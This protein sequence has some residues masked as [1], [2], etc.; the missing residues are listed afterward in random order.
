[1]TYNNFSNSQPIS[2]AMPRIPT[3]SQAYL[4]NDYYNSYKPAKT[5]PTTPYQVDLYN[6]RQPN[7]SDY[8][9]D[10]LK[11]LPINTQHLSNTTNG[12]AYNSVADVLLNKE[13]WKKRWGKN[14]WLMTPLGYAPRVII[15]SLMLLK[16]TTIDPVVDTV[17]LAAS[18]KDDSLTITKGLQTGINTALMNTLINAG[19]TFDVLA[20][21]VKGFVLEGSDGFVK[22]LVGTSEEGRKQYDYSDHV[23]FGKGFGP[24]VG[25][26]FASML[27]EIFSDPL[28]YVSFGIVGTA[29]SGAK[30][31][32]TKTVDV[33]TDTAEMLTKKG[34]KAITNEVVEQT[35]DN[36]LDKTIKQ[37]TNYVLKD[38][39]AAIDVVVDT[40][41]KKGFHIPDNVAEG[42]LKN[43]VNADGVDNAAVNTIKQTAPT[44][45]YS[46]LRQN[47]A[48][49]DVPLDQLP[50][51]L[52]SQNV[53]QR[54]A[55][56]ADDGKA[57]SPGVQNYFSHTV[58]VQN[59]PSMVTLSKNLQ[60]FE[61]GFNDAAKY[62]LY[63]TS[64]LFP[65]ALGKK[66]VTKLVK[67]AVATRMASKMFKAV[68]NTDEFLDITNNSIDFDGD[69]ITLEIPKGLPETTN[70]KSDVVGKVVTD[71][72][73]TVKDDSV[74]ALNAPVTKAQLPQRSTAATSNALVPV[75]VDPKVH[76]TLNE[77]VDDLINAFRN[78]LYLTREHPSYITRKEFEDLRSK[79]MLRIEEVFAQRPMDNIL[80]FTNLKTYTEYLKMLDS[81]DAPK[82]IKQLNEKFN[83][84]NKWFT[85][86]IDETFLTNLDTSLYN[87]AIK[88]IKKAS[89]QADNIT[90]ADDLITALRHVYQVNNAEKLDN[91]SWKQLGVSSELSNIGK[92][93]IDEIDLTERVYYTAQKQS[94]V[95]AAAKVYPNKL[96]DISERGLEAA[97][98][99]DDAQ[100]DAAYADYLY[101]L[102]DVTAVQT[103]LHQLIKK[104][105][106][107]VTDDYTDLIPQVL[108][109]THRTEIYKA[110]KKYDDALQAVASEYLTFRNLLN[111]D[112]QQLAPEP[113]LK[114]NLNDL[115]HAYSLAVERLPHWD[116][117]VPYRNTVNVDDIVKYG[118]VGYGLMRSKRNLI[119]TLLENFG[120][121]E[122][123]TGF[124]K[125]LTEYAKPNSLLYR[126]LHNERYVE[127]VAVQQCI[128]SFDNIIGYINLIKQIEPYLSSVT[129]YHKQG[130]LDSVVTKLT[131]YGS[132][133]EYHI[134]KTLE[135]ILDAADL[136]AQT[137]FD[138]PKL[139]LDVT[140]WNLARKFEHSD[141]TAKAYYAGLLLESLPKAHSAEADVLNTSY[142][143]QLV[144]DLK[145]ALV[146]RSKGRN[147]LVLDIE[148]T[149]IKNAEIYQLSV[150]ML[151]PNGND[152][153]VFKTYHLPVTKV[154]E[155]TVLDKL[156]QAY[157]LAPGETPEQW[158]TRAYIKGQVDEIE[159]SGSAFSALQHFQKTFLND[160][161]DGQTAPL[162]VGHNLR[163][164]DMPTLVKGT[165]YNPKLKT[166]FKNAEVFDTYD[167]LLSQH[168]WQLDDLTRQ[169]LSSQLRRVFE[170]SDLIN[171]G[172]AKHRLID[173]G[174]LNDLNQ[175]KKIFDDEVA[176]S[177][178]T[179]FEKFGTSNGLHS[180][181][182]VTTLI[183]EASKNIS[184]VWKE[185]S[186]KTIQTSYVTSKTVADPKV[187][188]Q[189]IN[190]GVI[191]MPQAMNIMSL[192]N[193]HIIDEEKVILNPYTMY[194]YTFSNYFDPQKLIDDYVLSGAQQNHVP[195][196]TLQK[197]TRLSKKLTNVRNG[198]TAEAVQKAYKFS[199]ELLY[200]LKHQTDEDIF[201][202]PR[203]FKYLYDVNKDMSKD[204][205]VTIALYC[206]QQIKPPEDHRALNYLCKRLSFD[207]L[208]SNAEADKAL[209]KVSLQDLDELSFKK[210]LDVKR[211]DAAIAYAERGKE[212][213]TLKLRQR[214]QYETLRLKRMQR[215]AKEWEQLNAE[216][217]AAWKIRK[218]TNE[219]LKQ[220]KANIIKGEQEAVLRSKIRNASDAARKIWA[221]ELGDAEDLAR[222]V[223]QNH[224]DPI[225]TFKDLY[226]EKAL[227]SVTKQVKST[228]YG[229]THTYTKAW[230]DLIKDAPEDVQTELFKQLNQID[231]NLT[232][233]GVARIL[234]R[235]DR[236]NALKR[237]A[238]FTGGRFAFVTDSPVDLS[239]FDNDEDLITLIIPIELENTSNPVN[240]ELFIKTEGK[241]FTILK[242]SVQDA[243]P[244][245]VVF[246]NFIGVKASAYQDIITLT[247]PLTEAQLKL[248]DQAGITY[249]LI[250]TTDDSGRT[251]YKYYL[252]NAEE[253]TDDFYTKAVNI[254]NKN[255]NPELNKIVEAV[256]TQFASCVQYA[257][258]S[259]GD[260]L[261]VDLMTALDKYL[262]AGLVEQ[263]MPVHT[264]QMSGFFN[265]LRGNN[266]LIGNKQVQR[267]FNPYYAGNIINRTAYTV[268]EHIDKHI[269]SITLY[270]NFLCNN[271][272]G[273][274]TNPA[275]TALSKKDLR[276]V[277]KAHPDW[278]VVWIEPCGK[279]NK[280]K[281][282]FVVHS[283]TDFS[284]RTL[285]AAISVNAHV[286]PKD[287]M[288]E[289]MQ[290]INTF[291]LPNCVKWLQQLSLGYKLGYLSSIGTIIRNLIDSNYKNHLDNPHAF[292]IPTQVKR[293]INSYKLLSNYNDI[294]V[295]YTTASGTILS[296]VQ[297]YNALWKLCISDETTL[298]DLFARND[299][300]SRKLQQLQTHLSVDDIAYIKGRLLDPDTFDLVHGF[301][302]NGPSA[303][304][305]QKI[306]NEL[307]DSGAEKGLLNYITNKTPLKHLYS[308]NE[309]VEQ[310]ARFSRYIEELESGMSL[311]EAAMS[312][313]KT[314]FDYSDKS[315]LMMYTELIFPFMSFSFKNLNYWLDTISKN[316]LVLNEL[317]N[318][319]RSVLNYQSLFEPDYE[320]YAAYDYSF[321]FKEDVKGFGANAPWQLINAA[322][323]YHLLSGNLIIDTDKIVKHDNGYGEKDTELFAVFKLS[324]SILDAVKMLYNPLDT[325][326]QRLLPPAEILGNTFVN[327][328][329]GKA[330][331]EE[332]GVNTLLNN[333]PFIGAPLQRA[334]VGNANNVHKRIKDAGLPMA[335]TSL[336]TAAYVPTKEH[337][338]WYD[339]NYNLLNPL[340]HQTYYTSPYYTS[341][342]FTPTYSTKRNFSN[343][344]NS[345]VPTYTINKLARRTPNKRLYGRSVKYGVKNT[346]SN[347]L[348]RGAQ[349]NLIR[350]RVLDKFKYFN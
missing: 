148:T 194:N 330:P 272:N 303:G 347:L 229:A 147:I 7:A 22:G 240:P 24:G 237:E 280:T 179:L 192:L 234:N 115:K 349:D 104:Y 327:V 65:L 259:T 98:I 270:I 208:Y 160:L 121:D 132:F 66:G 341:G 12:F 9:V 313:I 342:G 211:L 142:L 48:R 307:I 131:Q 117:A 243:V 188:N 75:T 68:S 43:I 210:S 215:N 122:L 119:H 212:W 191:N 224:N 81:Y 111:K 233:L 154:P 255:Y 258:C 300:L 283:I 252:N 265:T 130:I 10:V 59:L 77:R 13:A 153:G 241:G 60:R 18:D 17:K 286:I 127:D 269:D 344:Y 177:N 116:V 247:R 248:Y 146:E 71:A 338:K 56:Q 249:K 334:G 187:Y 335:L 46:Q 203:E 323:L 317:E 78:E 296:D 242:D 227:F 90:E 245:K 124:S 164:F 106:Y 345:R 157:T 163:K 112:V 173:Y 108:Q 309:M 306:L 120:N 5:L 197:V 175:I 170:T 58:D 174:L 285:D 135:D 322:R 99:F 103:E 281:S 223:A 3:A 53:L 38:G 319:L 225:L 282:G 64:G 55:H 96:H 49:A 86:E 83:V 267:M 35:T 268:K 196:K 278:G 150:R 168:V 19:N 220:R 84:I 37:V 321:D 165:R 186:S 263:L 222:L 87:R 318:V 195:I 171:D 136:A 134:E 294:M 109:A 140:L 149:G 105:G 231:E 2:L 20:N 80:P 14:S 16:D 235:S 336:F 6:P 214:R 91:I 254:N 329:N 41:A 276:E 348:Q 182:P 350:K 298:K 89:N 50:S 184:D 82:Y 271:E 61:K 180:T 291:E 290:A 15:D 238:R 198:L 113:F 69:V 176:I 274:K 45:L 57:L 155:K 250:K 123:A 62:S 324:P 29:K 72:A 315:L 202:L 30:T 39:T 92:S 169:N 161:A 107:T 63:G 51:R 36:V 246:L 42:L 273:L 189:L 295:R 152:T 277:L 284:D 114:N 230:Y 88:V 333:L 332:I 206:A 257:G 33:F 217:E 312:V 47:I 331:F 299:T 181:D 139:S 133:N 289:L 1:M 216:R 305:S 301:I 328:L 128:K 239:D 253:I 44:Q 144:P 314:H 292:T 346:Y 26:F 73:D 190:D 93:L 79:Y 316:S 264:L 183:D 275:F 288:Y 28:T 172:A 25:E 166:F 185:F 110:W 279:Y 256:Q 304:L 52:R 213:R 141:D 97:G 4:P 27:F 126:I 54:L 162:I 340:P 143:F 221:G 137:R 226:D 218:E 266:M 102:A 94:E 232:K 236:V 21:P 85:S 204:D 138:V 156:T 76:S 158:F 167:Y 228:M 320:A 201:G 95:Y 67:K 262:P 219:R 297:D 251:V 178:S 32:T 325:Y 11:V 129:P 302:N 293:L 118:L 260:V 101:S 125:L 207:K 23:E 74:K 199:Y 70:I 205:V 193:R 100:I 31:L 145:S 310:T 343:P 326:A 339:D 151:D 209:Y 8:I 261:T 200:F 311:S 337:Y 159:L 40:A 244:N 34:A 308:A 287:T